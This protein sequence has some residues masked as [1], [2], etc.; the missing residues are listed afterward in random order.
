MKNTFLNYKI[1]LFLILTLFLNGS[2]KLQAQGPVAQRAL[3]T[4]A[5]D[6]MNDLKNRVSRKEDTPKNVKGSYYFNKNFLLS[7]VIYFGKELKEKAYL[8]YNAANDE[9][10]MGNSSSQKDTEE[11]LLKSTKVNAIIDNEDYRLFSYTPKANKFPIEGYLVVLVDD[12][13]YSLYIKRKKVY[14]REVKART[15]LERSSPARFISNTSYYFSMD[16]SAPRPLKVNRSSV[17]NLFGSKKIVKKFLKENK[18]KFKSSKDLVK[19][20]EFAN[21]L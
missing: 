2:K 12:D 15:S 10:E 14:M 18:I 7:K 17:L 9:I 20:F 19:V 6:A 13:K 21:S 8:R 4:R 16:R 3:D 1:Y 5:M 11:I